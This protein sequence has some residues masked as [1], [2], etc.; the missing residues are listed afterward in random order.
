MNDPS[1]DTRM[2]TLASSHVSHDIGIR[3]HPCQGSRG[4]FPYI[5]L[6]L[7]SPEVYW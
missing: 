2:P 6:V 1:L 4:M 5:E 3:Q 7:F